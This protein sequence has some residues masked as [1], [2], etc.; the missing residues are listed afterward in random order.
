METYSKML[1]EEAAQEQEEAE[2]ELVEGAVQPRAKILPTA[3]EEEE[4][5]AG[6]QDLTMVRTRMLEI[7]KVLEDFKTLSEEGRSRT[8]YMDRLIKD[9]CEYFGYTPIHTS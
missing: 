4:I 7:V 5:K 8:E 3:E 1:D 6:P 2:E 9:I